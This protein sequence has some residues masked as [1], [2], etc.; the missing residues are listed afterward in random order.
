MKKLF[1]A[2]LILLGSMVTIAPALGQ[3]EQ[4]TDI[5]AVK[6]RYCNDPNNPQAKRLLLE[7]EPE[8][9]ETICI[10]FI[11][12]ASTPATIGINFVD[13]TLTNDSSQNKACLAEW[14]KQNFWQYV[15]DYPDV[16]T[17]PAQS[18]ERIQA[19]LLYSGGYAG[20]SY[21][22]LTF[23]AL[24]EWANWHQWG[25]SVQARVGSFIDVFVDGDFVIK[26]ASTLVNADLYHNIT[27]NPNFIIYRVERKFS[28][29][30]SKDFWTYKVKRNVT[31]Q[32][33]IGTRGD[34]RLSIRSWFVVSTHKVLP[35]QDILPGQT[36]TFEAKIPRYMV[37]LSAWPLRIKGE[38]SYD[39]I[40][41]G[42]QADSI[43]TETL[44]LQ[45]YTSHF[46]VPRVLLIV[47][48]GVLYC[49]YHRVRLKRCI[50]RLKRKLPKITI[51]R[52]E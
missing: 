15:S 13:G 33:N 36:R 20:T 25:I 6:A 49:Y 32:G 7:T 37:W 48:A 22:C 2:S 52:G 16:V 46:F 28:K 24:E 43:P 51:T 3:S 31:N 30:F 8:T 45:D 19:T 18:T 41:L 21:G 4:T 50:H 38:I 26:L 9:P 47:I 17:I 23:H 5:R 1:F 42:S 44:V 40:Y 35:D 34:L 39:G 14:Q 29:I 10:D 12:S 27:R 11:N